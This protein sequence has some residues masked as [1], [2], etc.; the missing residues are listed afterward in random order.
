MKKKILKI[1]IILLFIFILAKIHDYYSYILEFKLNWDIDFPVATKKIYYTDTGASFN[2]D[3]ITYGVFYY[4]NTEKIDKMLNWQESISDSDIEK[5]N[6]LNDYKFIYQN[7]KKLMVYADKKQIE[8]VLYNLISNAIKYGGDKKVVKIKIIDQKNTYK[9][10]IIDE[11]PGIP[12]EDLDLIW[13]KY[14]RT[15]KTHQRSNTGTGLGLS[16]VKSILVKHKFD[17]GVKSTINKGSTFY[18][19]IDKKS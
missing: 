4:N 14:Y 2:G 13:D 6:Y 1:I 9:V 19:Q 8:Q 16:I 5:F 18:F 11:G 7:Q 15:D 10:E 3:G 17:Y 12:K